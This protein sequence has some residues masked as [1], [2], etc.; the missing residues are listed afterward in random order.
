MRWAR[1]QCMQCLKT[2]LSEVG[3]EKCY[4]GTY[5]TS[6]HLYTLSMLEVRTT[7]A[8]APFT[9][10]TKPLLVTQLSNQLY[11]EIHRISLLQ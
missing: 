4:C 5:C 7:W 1:N 10:P 3:Y 6:L 9:P 11:W 2:H 8:K